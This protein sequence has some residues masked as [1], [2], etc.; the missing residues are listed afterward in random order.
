MR[1]NAVEVGTELRLAALDVDLDE[2]V[3]N[4]I[5]DER[6]DFV[7]GQF[8]GRRCFRA[9]TVTVGALEIA[10]VR[11]RERDLRWCFELGLHCLQTTTMK[12]NAAMSLPSP[13]RPGYR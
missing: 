8:P 6:D 13:R 2:I 10:R 5:V 3:G 1:K 9:I 4:E 12:S 11:D 7:R